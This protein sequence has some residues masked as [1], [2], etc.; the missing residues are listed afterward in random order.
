MPKDIRSSLLPGAHLRSGE[1][2]GAVADSSPP[3]RN[4]LPPVRQGAGGFKVAGCGALW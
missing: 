1:A 2:Q 4:P 3:L